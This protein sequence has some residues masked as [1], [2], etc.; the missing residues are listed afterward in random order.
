MLRQKH[1]Y[2][3]AYRGTWIEMFFMGV[4]A[5]T[6]VIET[7]LTS[8]TLSISNNYL[9]L[10]GVIA[11]AF[12]ALFI[13]V[14]ANRLASDVEK[15][16]RKI[17]SYTSRKYLS[18]VKRFTFV[19]L[20]PLSITIFSR[21]DNEQLFGI[22]VSAIL[23]TLF[24]NYLDLVVTFFLNGYSSGFVDI[25]FD[26]NIWVKKIQERTHPFI[27]NIITFELY[28]GNKYKGYDKFTE[29]DYLVLKKNIET[30]EDK[31]CV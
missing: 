28:F 18:I 13:Q 3:K 2:K 10:L 14:R 25:R 15:G 27:E 12:L 8:N 20:F 26:S 29:E 17:F 11:L 6:L 23:I 9:K 31:K 24:K 4:L 19:T 30:K 21:Q 7:N 1:W 5:I 16:E 22:I